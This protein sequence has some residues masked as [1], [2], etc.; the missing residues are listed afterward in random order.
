MC[1][2]P[3]DSVGIFFLLI[4]CIVDFG[5]S[6]PSISCPDVGRASHRILEMKRTVSVLVC[7]GPV[8]NQQR[9][10]MLERTWTW[11]LLKTLE[12]YSK[13]LLRSK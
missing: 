6:D 12:H 7:D 1:E 3:L 11:K 10:I 2:R 5:L 4:K 9:S 13:A 8:E